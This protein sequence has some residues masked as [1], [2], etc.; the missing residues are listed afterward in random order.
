MS[1]PRVSVNIVT[2]NS[3]RYLPELLASLREQTFRDFS[4]LVIDNASTDGVIV[5]LRENYP[6]VHILRNAKNL[7]FSGAH[8]Q[9]I[10][11]ALHSWRGETL[12]ERYVLVTNPDIIM[13]PDFLAELV[14]AADP[15]GEQVGGL[16]GKLLRAERRG[17]ET[18]VETV[19]TVIIDSTG[20][21]VSRSR[22]VFD[23]GSGEIDSGQYDSEREV[24][25]ISG[26][27]ALYRA[28]ALV[29][30]ALGEEYFDEQFFA[31]K[32]DADLAWRMRLLGF[33]ARYV[34]EAV[35]YHFRRTRDAHR[36]SLVELLRR[37]RNK[38]ALVNFYSYR[39][40]LSMLVKNE[41]WRNLILH[42]PWILL[43]ELGKLGSLLLFEPKT[44][45]ALFSFFKT[46]PLM[47]AKRWIIMTKARVPAHDIRRWF[48]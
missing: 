6:E 10:K 5:F 26:A 47:L 43:Y 32:E 23:R 33:S 7:G 46:L 2:W 42:A 34:P 15:A 3:M 27:L 13:P 14:A 40:H 25:G 11:F 30:T 18:L 17:E 35:A 39:N 1:M 16:G 48:V 8:N 44:L 37:R 4:V 9:G 28:S 21:A 12:T 31:Y 41:H 22:R 29:A 38:S 45:G 19:R 36:A 24:F 20:L